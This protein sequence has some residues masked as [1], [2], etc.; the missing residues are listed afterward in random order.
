MGCCIKIQSYGWIWRSLVQPAN[1]IPR[2]KSLKMH[3]FSSLY[4]IVE[5]NPKTDMLQW[6]SQYAVHRQ[7]VVRIIHSVTGISRLGLQVAK[8]R[9][10][11]IPI[12]LIY[13][14]YLCCILKQPKYWC[15]WNKNYY[16]NLLIKTKVWVRKASRLE[17]RFM[18]KVRLKKHNKI[19]KTCTIGDWRCHF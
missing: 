2:C 3:I 10:F 8:R 9:L 5:E 17:F 1:Y 19:N 18:A 13:W 4:E 6:V 11:F 14:T 15:P 12:L 16:R 7:S